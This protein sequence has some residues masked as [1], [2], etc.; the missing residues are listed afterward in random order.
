MRS[1]K[2]INARTVDEACSLLREYKGKAMLNAGG[3]EL[4]SILK[5]EY[6]SDYPEAVIN[7]KT[8]SGLDY[9]KEEK[10]SIEDR[11][12]DKA[13]RHCEVSASEEWL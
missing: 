5:G 3:T 10:G 2:H 9:I 7:I 13:L 1:F 4:L 11:R 8:L 6:L 12:S